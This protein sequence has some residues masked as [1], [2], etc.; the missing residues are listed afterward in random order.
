MFSIKTVQISSES[1]YIKQI[2]RYR[3]FE[4]VSK[5]SELFSNQIQGHLIKFNDLIEVLLKFL[6]SLIDHDVGSCQIAKCN[7][8]Y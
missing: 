1:K 4:K 3:S 7:T 6:F 5:I 2:D 8:D